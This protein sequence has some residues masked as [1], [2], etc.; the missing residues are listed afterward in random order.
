MLM[1]GINRDK[2]RNAEAFDLRKRV[3]IL[4]LIFMTIYYGLKYCIAKGPAL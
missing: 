3:I 1:F 2:S 4:A